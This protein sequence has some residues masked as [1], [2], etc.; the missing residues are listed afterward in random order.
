[1]TFA[2]L[3]HGDLMASTSRGARDS[4][5]RFVGARVNLEN[6]PR[7]PAAVVASALAEGHEFRLTWAPVVPDGASEAAILRPEDEHVVVQRL[8]PGGWPLHV[9]VETRPL[10]RRGGR[11]VLLRCPNCTHLVRHLYAWSHIGSG[12]VIRSSWPCRRCAGLRYGSEG[13]RNPWS[14]WAGPRNRFPWD[15]EVEPV[16]P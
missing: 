15:P 13:W 5:G 14:S 6:V 2:Y 10:P 16:A 7:L 12:R 3:S 8:G 9:E 4:D 11:A 1:M